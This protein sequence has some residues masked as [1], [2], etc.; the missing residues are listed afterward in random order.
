[1]TKPNQRGGITHVD[2]PIP[3]G[4]SLQLDKHEDMVE[5]CGNDIMARSTKADIAPICQGALVEPL[6]YDADCETA[7]EILP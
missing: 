3:G 1:M 4:P 2:V 6:G 5:A 7:V